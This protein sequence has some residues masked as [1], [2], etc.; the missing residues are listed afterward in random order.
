MGSLGQGG[1]KED[2]DGVKHSNGDQ[3]GVETFPNERPEQ[4][5]AKGTALRER[6]GL[7]LRLLLRRKRR[8]DN[9]L[10]GGKVSPCSIW[11]GESPHKIITIAA[12]IIC[13]E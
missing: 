4:L 1:R 13:N 7:I 6:E 5:V 12:A 9:A 8:I 3:Q 2:L 10:R 11:G